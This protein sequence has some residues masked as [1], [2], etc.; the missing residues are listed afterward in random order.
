MIA[1]IHTTKPRTQRYVDAFVKGAGGSK[2]HQ[3]RDLKTL[4]EGELVMYG[5]LAGSG[6]IYQ[7][8]V[9]ENKTFYYMDHSYFANAHDNPHWLHVTR[10]KH[11]QNEITT[12]KTVRY[13]KFWKRDLK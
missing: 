9:S 8:C 7:Q 10:N 1:G 12:T 5:I 4:P 3:F 6:E 13:E 2:I 11:R